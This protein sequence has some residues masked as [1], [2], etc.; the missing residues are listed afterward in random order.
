[1]RK[2]WKE[3]PG[4]FNDPDESTLIQKLADGKI[5]VEVGTFRGRSLACIAEKATIVYSVDTFKSHDNGQSQMQFYTTLKETQE[6]L[7]GYD[8]VV[9][10]PGES[11]DIAPTFPNESVDMVFID[12][13]HYY[14]Y[15]MKD[16]IFWYPKIKNGGVFA[17]HDNNYPCVS[18]ACIKI[19]SKIE[20]MGGSVI[21]SIKTGDEIKTAGKY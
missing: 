6:N 19:F 3:I 9:F 1:M 10:L 7:R 17:F 16:I 5:V 14:E 12:G 21:Y 11:D 8:N 18:E 4:C 2:N 20:G 15:V 13:F